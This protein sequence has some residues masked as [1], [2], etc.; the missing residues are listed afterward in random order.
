MCTAILECQ[1]NLITITRCKSYADSS[2][3]KIMCRIKLEI[4]MIGCLDI[5]DYDQAWYFLITKTPLVTSIIG[6]SR[7]YGVFTKFQIK[8]WSEFADRKTWRTFSEKTWY[9]QNMLGKIFK[10]KKDVL[11]ILCK[12]VQM[13][14]HILYQSSHYQVQASEF[15]LLILKNSLQ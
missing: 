10:C 11:I 6:L 2:H 15:T 7:I 14:F 13:Y 8:I 3:I 4:R 12:L 5:L 9:L 1:K